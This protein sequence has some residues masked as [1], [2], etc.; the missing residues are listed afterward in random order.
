MFRGVSARRGGD[1]PP[2]APMDAASSRRMRRRVLE[3]AIDGLVI[4][5]FRTPVLGQVGRWQAWP[6]VVVQ[7]EEIQGRQQVL[8]RVVGPERGPEDGDGAWGLPGGRPG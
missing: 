5:G 2:I 7:G 3:R 8:A 4:H 6:A 1:C